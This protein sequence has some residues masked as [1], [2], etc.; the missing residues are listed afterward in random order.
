MSVGS[1]VNSA[2]GKI[3]DDLIPEG[4]GVP[5]TKGQLI[6]ADATGTETALPVGA[7]G[8]VLSADTG[9]PLGLRWIANPAG[10]PLDY[11]ELIS[12]NPANHTAI[13][14]APTANNYVLTSDNTGG[15]GSAG[16]A[17]K[18]LAGPS[19]T[20]TTIA[21]LQDLEPVAGTNELSIAFTAV[22][23]EIPAGTGVAKTGGLL[24]LGTAGQVLAVNTGAALGLEWIT[25]P[26]GT[27]YIP[28]FQ[29]VPSLGQNATLAPVGAG[30]G[31]VDITTGDFVDIP[32][33]SISGNPALNPLT[34]VDFYIQFEIAT[35]GLTGG[36]SKI[37]LNPVYQLATTS[38]GLYGP[39]LQFNVPIFSYIQL[40]PQLFLTPSLTYLGTVFCRGEIE[41]NAIAATDFIK[42]KVNAFCDTGTMDLNVATG[43]M[44]ISCN[45]SKSA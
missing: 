23:G 41:I 33:S 13:V 4:G 10:I 15:A 42:F 16:L 22:K 37:Y 27:G 20:I 2:T 34:F 44:N 29:E 28:Y 30:G 14:P 26:T 3:Y 32:I 38:G 35:A 8:S 43:L 39:D 36:A 17:W 12:A 18:P 5:L 11:Q 6:T 45:V 7:D 25:A 40:T 1:I 21:P 19:G 24:P 9:Q 31:A